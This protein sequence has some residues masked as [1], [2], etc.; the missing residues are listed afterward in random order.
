MAAET[1][2]TAGAR[3]HV[4][5]RMR[6]PARKLLLAG[7]GGLNLTHSEP[8]PTFLSRYADATAHLTPALQSFSPAALRQWAQELGCETFVGS[9]GRVFPRAF[10]T[11]PLLRPWLQ[12]LRNAGVEFHLQHRWT[13]WTDRQA[14]TFDGPEGMTVAAAD[15]T[16]L[17]LGGG[18]WP[19]L[20]ANGDWVSLLVAAGVPVT[21]LRAANCGF[22]VAW[23]DHFR[24]RFAGQPLKRLRVTCVD[25]M[26]QPHMVNGELLI[27]AHGIEGGPA[28]ALGH[29]LR[30]TLEEQA[31]AV[32][33]VDLLPEQE[34]QALTRRLS[35]PRGKA[36]FAKHLKR[37]T[38]IDG[39]KA[40][41]LREV[42]TP[43]ELNDP[44]LVAATL[45]AVPLTLVAARPLAEAISTA[46]GVAFTAMDDQFM[47]HARPATFCAGEMLDWDAPTGGYL[48]SACLATGRWAAL[49]AAAWLGLEPSTGAS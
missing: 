24:M 7:R 21:P 8:L 11:S 42:L 12:R 15:A 30:P 19:H 18:S 39:S 34:L 10:K 3:V 40:A 32:I 35:K 22:D 1:L 26:Q 20:G 23:S 47:L 14:L 36:T 33:S 28:Y 31:A 25:N 43:L 13:G 16:V 45:K 48:L 9:S 37:Q 41:L 49:G 38:G 6:S 17:A 29:V 5:D 2:V 44:T 27:T 46:G 4:Y